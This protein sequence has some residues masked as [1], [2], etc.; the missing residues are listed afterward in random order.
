MKTLSALL[1]F[2]VVIIGG[3]AG[4]R[5]SPKTVRIMNAEYVN[6]GTQIRVVGF[7]ANARYVFTCDVSY[8]NAHKDLLGTCE[9]PAVGHTY[10][11][12][13]LMRRGGYYLLPAAGEGGYDLVFAL[14]KSSTKP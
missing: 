5:T 13:L 14:V 7:A 11:L 6:N 12:L 1:F 3:E 8:W 4:A 9:L 10:Q 2:A